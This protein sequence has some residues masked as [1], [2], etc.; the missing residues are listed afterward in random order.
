MRKDA[1][2]YREIIA[3][4]MQASADKDTFFRS[5][6][7]ETLGRLIENTEPSW[8]VTDATVRILFSD[9]TDGF[10]A[11][12]AKKVRGYDKPTAGAAEDPA[13]D[14]KI[15]DE[16]LSGLVL[17]AYHD[18]DFE[19]SIELSHIQY[20][21]RERN[22]LMDDSRKKIQESDVDQRELR[23]SALNKFKF[24]GQAIGCVILTSPLAANHEAVDR[25]G[26]AILRIGTKSGE[27]GA[28]KFRRKVDSLTA[29]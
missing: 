25:A 18:G 17:R 27:V 6:I 22:A 4:G 11:R 21:S 16:I 7:A 23:A 5:D 8:D 1:Q 14:H 12:G 26:K 13:A 9:T 3:D 2:P 19:T 15:I 10:W 29:D 24:I 28:K 20:R